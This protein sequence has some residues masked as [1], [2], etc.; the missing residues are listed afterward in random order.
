MNETGIWNLDEAK[1]EHAFDKKLASEL[2]KV[3]PIGE[4]VIDL[5][6]GRGDYLAYLDTKGFTCVG[7]EGTPDIKSIAS[8][9][10]IKQADLSKPLQTEKGTVLCFE[11]AEHIP[12]E[13]EDV[14]LFNVA[15]ASTGLLIISW[16]VKGQGG[17]GHVNEQ[18]SEYVINKFQKLGYTKHHGLTMKLRMASSLWW[19][20][21]SIYVFEKI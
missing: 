2:A 21:K 3:L 14:F 20:K 19:F 4:Y 13:Y 18:D 1:V 8:F 17:H 12:K 11:V 9:P 5:G 6:C 16:A 7:Y 10:F 15:D